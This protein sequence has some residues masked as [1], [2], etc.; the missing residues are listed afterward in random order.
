MDDIPPYLPYLPYLLYLP[1]D[2]MDDIAYI[3]PYLPY[4]TIYKTKKKNFFSFFFLSFSVVCISPKQK[5][6]ISNVAQFPKKKNI[7]K[8]AVEKNNFNLSVLVLI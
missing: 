6:N 7:F 8:V 2:R 5:N 3:L 4:R 1:M